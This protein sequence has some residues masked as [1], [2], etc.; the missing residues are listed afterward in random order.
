MFERCGRAAS[1][2]IARRAGKCVRTWRD[3]GE[4]T[5]KWL[6]RSVLGVVLLL[7]VGAGVVWWYARAT[8]PQT[9]G[10]LAVA[11]LGAEVRIERDGRGI[12]TIHAASAESAMFGLGF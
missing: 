4:A 10:T 1:G 6:R 11:G 3:H 5:M 9:D 2:H 12:P 8:L 7:V